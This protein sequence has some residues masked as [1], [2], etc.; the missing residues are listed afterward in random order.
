MTPWRIESRPARRRQLLEVTQRGGQSAP[1]RTWPA[2]PLLG[3]GGGARDPARRNDLG[4]GWSG[5]ATEPSRAM[6]SRRQRVSRSALKLSPMGIER[7]CKSGSCYGRPRSARLE[8]AAGDDRLLLHEV[9]DGLAGLGAGSLHHVHGVGDLAP[10]LL[11]Q[12]FA[13]PRLVLDH[14]QRE[15]GRRLDDALG[16]L[17]VL[18][19]RELDEDLVALRAVCDDPGSPRS[20]L[21]R[22]SASGDSFTVRSRNCFRRVVHFRRPAVRGRAHSAFRTGSSRAGGRARP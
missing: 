19:A 4:T 13:T 15:L 1:R 3:G 10:R 11:Q 21:T 18:H 14:L 12:G 8:V 7:K 9:E 6:A 20:W 17:D 5:E 16:L 2:S 22:R